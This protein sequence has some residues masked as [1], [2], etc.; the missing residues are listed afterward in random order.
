MKLR[1]CK[2]CGNYWRVG[3]TVRVRLNKRTKNAEYICIL[4]G[5][6]RTLNYAKKGMRGVIEA[7]E[8]GK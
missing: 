8:G 5:A 2:K 1:F 4:C 3:K 6:K 7:S